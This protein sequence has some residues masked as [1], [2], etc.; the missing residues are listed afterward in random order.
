[1]ESLRNKSA[2]GLNK[3]GD[4]ASFA[5]SPWRPEW[6]IRA[7]F[8]AVIVISILILISRFALNIADIAY[9][10]LWT[11]TGALLA[12]NGI[13]YAYERLRP[14]SDSSGP[15]R[16]T[17][18]TTIQFVIDL[19]LLT[20]LVHY[21]GG[22]TNPFILVYVLLLIPSSILLPK[23][24]AYALAGFASFL[25]SLMTVLE[26][27]GTIPHYPL[28]SA[29]I[30]SDPVFAAGMIVAFTAVALLTAHLSSAIAENLR[31]FRFQCERSVE[32][33]SRIE[34]E[35]THFLDVVAHDL[36]SPLSAIETMVSSILDAYGTEMNEDTRDTLER[37]PVRT[38]DLIRFIQ[39][40]LDFTQIRGEE[41]ISGY[42][43]PLN[44]LPIVTSTVEMYT[45]QAMDKNIAMTVQ[46]EPNLPLILGSKE[47][48]ERMVANLISNAVRYTPENGSIKVKLSARND[49][50]ALTIADSGIGI[51]EKEISRVFEEFYRG[52]NAYKVSSGTGLGLPIVKF[53]VD[54]H[55]GAVS[56]NSVEGEGTVFTITLPAMPV[57]QPA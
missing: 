42:F 8:V 27:I 52:S 43:R 50:T 18:F 49:L 57:K 6:F 7:R 37:I 26:G 41:E 2:N 5:E 38:R 53:I 3:N 45:D 10:R 40:L 30:H 19:I 14:S 31:F 55:G 25:F 44:F 17:L 16:S 34:M 11:I 29:V 32:E 4:Q 39:N 36:K 9:I 48:L 21:S 28:I 13:Y 15:T 20:L 54:K 24:F 33:K 35:K 56:V 47:H 22:A 46:V 12:L 51:P 1:M 23:R